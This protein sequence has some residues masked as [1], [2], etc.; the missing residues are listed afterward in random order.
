MGYQLFFLIC[1]LLSLFQCSGH[2][3]SKKSHDFTSKELISA[4][5]TLVVE[6]IKVVLETYLWRDFMPFSPPDGKPMRAVITLLPTNSDFL[7]RHLD[8]SRIWVIFQ[9]EMWSS[10]LTAIGTGESSEPRR[11]LEKMAANGPKWGPG[12]EVTVVVEIVDDKGKSHLLK[13]D[14]QTI[15]RTD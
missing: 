2:G 4:P 6:G 3:G 11:R 9:K 10:S 5:D 15:H 13:C 12:V 14:R 7:P 8:A 1:F